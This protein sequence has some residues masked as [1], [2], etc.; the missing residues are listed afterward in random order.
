MQRAVVIF[1]QANGICRLTS[2]V[3]ASA[4][5]VILVKYEMLRLLIKMNA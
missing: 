2:Y 3:T 1:L 5:C 4:I